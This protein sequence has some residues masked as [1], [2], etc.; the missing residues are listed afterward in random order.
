MLQEQTKTIFDKENQSQKSVQ[1]LKRGDARR[2][3]DGAA[4]TRRRRDDDA[5]TVNG[6]QSHA[7]SGTHKM[8]K[9]YLALNERYI[10]LYSHC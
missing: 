8:Y 6:C 3:G 5:T 7:G 10:T 9:G 4:T 1:L 2:P